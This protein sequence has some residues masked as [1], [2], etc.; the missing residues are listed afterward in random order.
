MTFR[1]SG[2][3]GDIVYGLCAVKA[4]RRS[5]IYL[6]VNGPFGFQTRDAYAILPL[7][8]AQE[9]VVQAEIWRGEPFDHDLDAFRENGTATPNLADAHLRV[10]GLSPVWRQESWLSARPTDSPVAHVIFARSLQ[11]RGAPGFWETCY[12]GLGAQAVFVGTD[13]EHAAFCYAVGPIRHHPTR[14]L[15]DLAR[16]IAGASLFVGNQSCPFAIAE[17]LKVPAIQETYGVANCIFER[18]DALQVA[19]IQDLPKIEPFF[20][21][22]FSKTK[23]EAMT[24]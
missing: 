10:I 11:H 1:H 9:Y 17:G 6:N 2:K 24:Q 3:L 22:V 16:T 14:N 7:L 8:R 20:G 4:C 13:A 18:E 5:T 21:A 12:R 15:L 19:S 23:Q